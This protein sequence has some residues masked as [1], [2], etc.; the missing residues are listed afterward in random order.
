MVLLKKLQMS[1]STEASIK[2]LSLRMKSIFGDFYKFICQI[3]AISQ[4]IYIFHKLQTSPPD[5]YQFDNVKYIHTYKDY[6]V[7]L[8]IPKYLCGIMLSYKRKFVHLLIAKC[9]EQR[10]TVIHVLYLSDCSHL[11]MTVQNQMKTL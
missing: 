8:Q 6:Q 7:S 11:H 1:S 9:Q 10:A 4:Q 2:F 3:F 5:S